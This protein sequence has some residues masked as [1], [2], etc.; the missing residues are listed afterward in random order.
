M[1]ALADRYATI[2]CDIDGVLARGHEAIDGAPEAVRALRGRGLRL[3]FVTNNASRTPAQVAGWLGALGIDVAAGE[4]LT[5]GAAAAWLLQPG[6]R[7]MVV[8]TD[9]VR[10]PLTERGCTLVTEPADADTVVVGFDPQLRYDDLRR[11]ALALQ[12]GARFVGTNGDTSF[13]AADGLWPGNGA[14]LALLTAATGREPELAGKPHP[15]LFRAAVERAG[16]R[17]P[18]L[19]VGDRLDTDVLGAHAAGWDS[20]LVLTGVA[21]RADAAAHDPPPTH[22]VAHVGDLLAA[23]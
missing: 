5:S 13:P 19:V 16:G 18:V 20:A 22:V 1:S 6:A 10:E 11:A 8:G 2:V 21:S 9:G 15:P 3:A 17:R 7:C 14:V 12:R 4:V 23:V